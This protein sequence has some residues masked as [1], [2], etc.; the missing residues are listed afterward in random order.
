MVVD[1]SIAEVDARTGRTLRAFP[2]PWGVRSGVHPRSLLIGKGS[3]LIVAFSAQIRVSDG[4][5]DY[6]PGAGGETWSGIQVVDLRGNAAPGTYLVQPGNCGAMASSG[7]D[8]LLAIG[9]RSSDPGLGG[10]L[11]QSESMRAPYRLGIGPLASEDLHG[12]AFSW[13]GRFL[14]GT[15]SEGILQWQIDPALWDPAPPM[16]TPEQT[17]TY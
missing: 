11:V 15:S 7:G 5:V 9:G 3:K 14:W 10:I 12:L 13:N 1:E 6:S 16:A 8:R 4:G 2:S 17:F